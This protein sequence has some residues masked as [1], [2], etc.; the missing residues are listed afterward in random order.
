[1]KLLSRNLQPIKVVFQTDGSL[2]TN[3]LK[4]IISILVSFFVDI[5]EVFKTKNW[6]RLVEIIFNLMRFG[7]IVQVAQEAWKELKDLSQPETEEIVKHISAVLDLENDKTERLIE[8]AFEVI[9]EVYQI[10]LDGL[11]LY[12]RSVEVVQELRSIFRGEDEELTQGSKKL[13][14]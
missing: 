6:F 2:G 10:A 11:G 4:G 1:M 9:P 12:N 5:V 7:N 13:A 3:N 14:A 8:R